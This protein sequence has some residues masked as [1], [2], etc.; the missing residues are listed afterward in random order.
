MNAV[1]ITAKALAL[2]KGGPVNAVEI[3]AVEASELTG[4]SGRHIR[5]LAKD[6]A[7]K[8]RMLVIGKQRLWY[9]IDKESLLVY[10]KRMNLMGTEKHANTH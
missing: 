4:Y 8:A 1:E 3:T 5:R 9:L 6:G 7:I 2:E 10:A